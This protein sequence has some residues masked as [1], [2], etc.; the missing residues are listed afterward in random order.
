MESSEGQKK[1]CRRQGKGEGHPHV[2][3][4]LVPT[5]QRVI[6]VQGRGSRGTRRTMSAGF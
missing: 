2:A 3:A 4:R 5:Q 6:E 1:S